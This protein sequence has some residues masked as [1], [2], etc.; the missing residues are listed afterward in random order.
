MDLDEYFSGQWL[1]AAD[2][3]GREVKTEIEEVYT[4][5]INNKVKVVVNF[6]GFNKGL[7]L[8]VTNFER[9][10]EKDGSESENWK[11]KSILLK[12]EKVPYKGEMVDAIRVSIPES[13]TSTIDKATQEVKNE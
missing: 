1:K 4:E 12:I 10:K 13:T 3:K 5:E 2:L 6:I 8:N 11:N 7:V 9:I